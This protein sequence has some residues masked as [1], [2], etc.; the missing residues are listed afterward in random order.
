MEQR[1]KIPAEAVELYTQYI[2]GDISRRD[3]FS[4]VERFAVAG[5]TAAAI[6][7]A[8]M[9]NYAL[10]QQVRKD[11]ER[12]KA[13]Y[14]TVPSPNGNGYVRG[15]FVRPFSQDTRSETPSKLPGVIVIH[16]NRGLNPHTE[17]VA[18]RFALENFM[19]FAPDLLT[20]AGGY[21][22][23]DYKGGQLFSKIDPGKRIEDLVA[24]AMW[25]KSRPDCTGKIAATGFCY[26]GSMSNMLAV[27]LGGDLAAAAPFYGGAPK[28]EDVPKIKAA[29]L[30][31][32]GALD[33]NLAEAYPAQEAELK[34]NNIRYEGH[35]Y[36]N[37]VHGFFND[38]T[39]ERYNKAA[40]EQA[41]N[42]T[43]EWFNQYT[44][45]G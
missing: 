33:K 21:P 11:D 42:R 2:H 23:D 4:G 8:L 41:W 25:L 18:R 22:G 7:E 37:S 35:V 15:Y 3:F 38:A 24:A 27:L 45:A 32:H 28:P 36:P 30:I 17:D 31:H 26:G 39:P 44:R 1:K 12:I 20:S 16:E 19:A 29:I 5:L 40:A 43:I 14:E 9:P 13:S 34:K 6:V 10:G